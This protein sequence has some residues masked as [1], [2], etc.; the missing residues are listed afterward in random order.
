[1]YLTVLG[2]P[3]TFVSPS[4]WKRAMG[5]NGTDKEFARTRA[6]HFFPTAELHRVKDHN[7]AEALLIAAYGRGKYLGEI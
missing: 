2:I 7:R 5:L 6:K 3:F 1:M 4:V